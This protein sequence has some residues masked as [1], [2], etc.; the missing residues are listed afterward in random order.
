MTTIISLDR[1]PVLADSIAGMTGQAGGLSH[2]W[3]PLSKEH[4]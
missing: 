2:H 1:K 3:K 4:I